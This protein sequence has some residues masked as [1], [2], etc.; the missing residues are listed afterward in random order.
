MS[1]LID[2]D[3]L[4]KELKLSA[5]YHA[6][7]SR[8]EVL[9]MRDR[10]IVREQPAVDAIPNSVVADMFLNAE[11]VVRCK[12]CKHWKKY[13]NGYGCDRL[14]V[15]DPEWWCKDGERKDERRRNIDK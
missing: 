4:L 11:I 10:D 8:D 1:D 3:K 9:M 6:Q 15:S 5:S 7:T 12:Y 14:D 13:V 2:R